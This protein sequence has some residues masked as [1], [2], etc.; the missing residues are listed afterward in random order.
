MSKSHT[1][2]KDDDGLFGNYLVATQYY[3]IITIIYV[4]I[5]KNVIYKVTLYIYFITSRHVNG[6][7]MGAH[8]LGA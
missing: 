8:L 3:Y 5:K 1:Q 6:E 2:V 4:N 7:R